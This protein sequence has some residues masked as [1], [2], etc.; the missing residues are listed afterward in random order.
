MEDASKHSCPR[1][2]ADHVGL[3]QYIQRSF[4]IKNW[5]RPKVFAWRKNA[6][7]VAEAMAGTGGAVNER[8]SMPILLNDGK[9]F[10]IIQKPARP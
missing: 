3:S 6:A 10:I 1:S 9:K 8:G 7:S 4:L 2:K 5:Y